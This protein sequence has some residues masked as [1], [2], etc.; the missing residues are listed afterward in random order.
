[1]ASQR[2]LKDWTESDKVNSLSAN[3]EVFFTRLIMK[4]DDYGSFH[5][6]PKLLK[7][8]LFPLRIDAV[9]DTDISRWTAEC[10]KAGLILVYTA[11]GKQYVR[12][13]DFGQRLRN[14]R[15]KFPDPTPGSNPPQSAAS[16]SETP[17]EVE[18][19]KKIEVED[20][21]EGKSG[22]LPTH[23]NKDFDVFA[24]W[25]G[26]NASQVAKM[27]DPFTLEEFE[28]IKKEFPAE[29]VR[30]IL[31]QMQ[32]KKDLTKKYTSAYLTCRNWLKRSFEDKRQVSGSGV[33]KI[34]TA[35]QN[36]V[37]V[38]ESLKEKYGNE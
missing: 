14:M 2:M 16:C 6:N 10:E 19:K 23:T 29:A 17:P 4:A 1:M 9:R 13:I 25:I 15:N 28:K 34:E 8:N 37:E 30:E 31:L 24:E 32:N 27:R 18:E 36:N 20:E 3:A 33:S 35:I 7:A 38:K 11:L 5:G 12:I 22:I 26:K 21:G